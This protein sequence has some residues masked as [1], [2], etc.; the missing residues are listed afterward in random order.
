MGGRG[1]D[2]ICRQQFLLEILYNAASCFLHGFYL[3]IVLKSF[4]FRGLISLLALIPPPPPPPVPRL[5]LLQEQ[6][7][8]TICQPK[9]S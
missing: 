6:S 3:F 4:S 7:V 5:L 9:R 2:S 1:G 8:M